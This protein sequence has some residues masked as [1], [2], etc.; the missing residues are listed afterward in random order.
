MLL[1]P[2]NTAATLPYFFNSTELKAVDTIIDYSPEI[3]A[4]L[5]FC[6]W[7]V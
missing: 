4:N 6:T 3:P 2:C 5:M 7:G 1:D